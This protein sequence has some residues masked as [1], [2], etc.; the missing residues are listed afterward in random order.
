M[1]SGP[2]QRFN[3]KSYSLKTAPALEPVSLDLLKSYLKVD[4]TD[5]DAVLSLL[6]KTA[7]RSAEEYTK[8][9]FVTQ[10]WLLTMDSFA[11]HEVDWLHRDPY[12]PPSYCAEGS[13]EIRLSRQ[14]I[15]SVSSIKTTDIANTQSTV[16]GSVYSLDKSGGNI[17]LNEG[18]LWP[19]NL[20]EYAAIEIEFVAG[21]GDNSAV[22]GDI[23]QAILQYAAAMYENRKCSDIPDGVKTL[24]DPYRLA[25]AF[26]A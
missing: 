15:Q 4:G 14:P 10:T 21:Y 19:F 2:R 13:Q 16:D 11:T 20:R 24:L 3:A 25:G 17:L 8:R 18:E 9:A 1:L 22:P 6:I 5:E 26:G 12:F 23:Q 7:R